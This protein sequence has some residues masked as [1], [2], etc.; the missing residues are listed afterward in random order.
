MALFLRGEVWWY[1][2]KKPTRRVVKST[3]FRRADRAQAEAVY[4]AAR[5]AMGVRPPR[6]VV[7]A[8]LDA[9]YSRTEPDA[10]P[11]ASVWTLY[12][13]WFRGKGK[14]VAA[15]T[16]A[17]RRKRVDDLAAWCAAR[18]VTDASRVDVDTARAYVEHLRRQTPPPSNKTLRNKVGDL[19]TVWTA[20]GQMR[21]GMHNPWTAAKPSDDGTSVRREPFSA[22]QRAAIMAAADELGHGWRGVCMAG[23]WT[24]QRYSDVAT[25]TYGDA[26]EAQSRRTPLENGVVDLAAGLLVLDP[27]KTRRHGTRI[28]IPI[29]AELRAELEKSARRDPG[30]FL[31]PEHAIAAA[32]RTEMEPP[33]RDVLARAGVTGV[34]YTFHSWRHTLR[35]M[36]ADAGVG[37]DIAN[38]F[39][40]WST[41]R[42]GAHYDHSAHISEMSAALAALK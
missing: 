16:L 38:R 4:Q 34:A 30:A 40:G 33:F 25:L 13:D 31:F 23:L 29:A 20:L 8:M 3:G 11:V 17:D 2:I 6:D 32:Q 28:A 10:L 14:Q 1:E 15:K 12:A 24:G 41:Q 36:L 37:D 21:P 39:G 27:S 19:E 18:R 9:I 22:G 5:I 7:K 26:R 42:M 35:S